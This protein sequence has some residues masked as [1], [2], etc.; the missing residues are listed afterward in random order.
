MARIERDPSRSDAGRIVVTITGEV[1]AEDADSLGTV[2]DDALE[3]R[4]AQLV[5]DLEGV[6]FCGSAGIRGLLVA[7][8]TARNVGVVL[9]VA[10]PSLAVERVVELTGV[11]QVLVI[12]RS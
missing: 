4:P 1:D 9:L 8:A 12:D 3:E 5:V 7:N 11:E 2:L 10:R 6:T